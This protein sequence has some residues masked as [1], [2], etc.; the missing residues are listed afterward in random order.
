ME[1]KNN[2]LLVKAKSLKS[3][4][5]SDLYTYWNDL[6]DWHAKVIERK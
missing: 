3:Q 5:V 2:E 6:V 1:S 4:L